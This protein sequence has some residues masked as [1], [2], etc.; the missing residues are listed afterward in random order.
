M[1]GKAERGQGS[2]DGI[3]DVEQCVEQRSVEVEY[4]CAESYVA[5]PLVKLS[6]L[7]RAFV[8]T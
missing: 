4:D 1:G 5:S 6:I 8:F 2:V 7:T 3:G